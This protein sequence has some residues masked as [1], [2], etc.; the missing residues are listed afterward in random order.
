MGP[1]MTTDGLFHAFGFCGHGF[2]LGPAVGAVMAEL[3]ATGQTDTPIDEFTIA[4]FAN[5]VS[6]SVEN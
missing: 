6:N 5:D 4:R 1:S 2:Q 3:I